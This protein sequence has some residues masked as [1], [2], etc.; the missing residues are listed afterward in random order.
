[1]QV[2]LTKVFGSVIGAFLAAML[3]GRYL[4]K[5]TLFRKM[6]LVAATSTAEGYSASLGE[7]KALLGAAGVAETNVRPGGNTSPSG[8]DRN[9][10][11]LALREYFERCARPAMMWL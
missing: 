7:A 4:P 3:L 5:S 1:M 9:C 10:M 11:V 6:E 8:D 2:P